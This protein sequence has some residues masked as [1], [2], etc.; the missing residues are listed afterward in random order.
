ML[1]KE[2]EYFKNNQNSLYQQYP[3]E[4]LVIKDLEVKYH[5]KTFE[6]A[7]E[8]AS[9]NFELGT[10]IVQQCTQGTEGY[11]QTFHSRVIFA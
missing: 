3:N 4:F 9:A 6:N 10:F 1:E 8:Y 11:T 7:L 2:F 5:A